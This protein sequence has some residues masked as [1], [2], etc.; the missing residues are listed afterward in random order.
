LTNILFHLAVQPPSVITELRQ[1]VE[2]TLEEHGWTKPAIGQMRKVDSFLKE[3]ARM[4]GL[5]GT[6]VNRKVLKPFTFSDGTNIPVGT[7][8]VVPAWSLHHDDVRNIIITPSLI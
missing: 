8:L 7:E 5:S 3:S 2:K 6:S 4:L 1:E